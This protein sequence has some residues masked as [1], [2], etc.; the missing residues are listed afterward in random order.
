MAL[1]K[2]NP[3][4]LSVVSRP[5]TDLTWMYFKGNGHT[6]DRNG[7]WD[8]IN[9]QRYFYIPALDKGVDTLPWLKGF[10]LTWQI[11]PVR[12]AAYFTTFFYAASQDTD[13][14]DLLSKNGYVGCH[15]YPISSAGEPSGERHTIHKW[16]IAIDAGDYLQSLVAYGQ[17]HTQAFRCR[18]DNSSTG[19]SNMRFYTQINSGSSNSSF[20][21]THS[22]IYAKFAPH[23]NKAIVIGNCPWWRA[24]QHERLSGFIRRIKIFSGTLSEADL[25]AEA[26]SDKLETTAGKSLIWW[27]K[28]NPASPDDLMSDFADVNGKRRQA[29]WID[30]AKCSIVRDQDLSSH[31]AFQKAALPPEQNPTH[32]ERG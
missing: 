3:T 2:S 14:Y 25:L 22:G 6:A 29:L 12:Q 1:I 8:R 26:L 9:L 21:Y 30:S 28:I 27:A 13:F 4:V 10:S 17:R 32:L 18:V 31:V 15:P 5:S 16:E 24:H 19:V 11:I 7:D 20:D 23:P